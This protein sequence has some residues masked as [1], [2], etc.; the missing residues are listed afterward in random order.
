MLCNFFR[1]VAL[2]GAIFFFI[3][4]PSIA[5]DDTTVEVKIVSV[6]LK[7]VNDSGA[8]IRGLSNTDFEVYEDGTKVGTT[9]FEEM[10]YDDKGQPVTT[11]TDV[12]SSLDNIY[13]FTIFLDLYNISQSE[14]ESLRPRIKEFL[15]Q[16]NGRAEVM[17][18]ALIPP[19]KLGVVAK[20]TPDISKISAI[21]DQAR[22]NPTRD[23]DEK[24]NEDKIV[25]LLKDVRPEDDP[26]DSVE[27]LSRISP[28]AEMN[29]Q[30]FNNAFQMA[31]TFMQ[32]DIHRAELSVNA[33][34]SF[35]NYLAANYPEGHASIVYVS[36]GYSSDPGRRYYD[37]IN[38]FADDLGF[39]RDQFVYS[40]RFP[41]SKRDRIFDIQKVIHQAIGKL[42]RTNI[43]VYAIN[44]RGMSLSRDNTAQL[45][46]LAT[47]VGKM[48]SDFQ[49]PLIEIANETG[50][51]SFQ[52]SQNFKV[53]FDSVLQDLQHQYTLCY[54]PP[55]HKKKNEF[56]EIKIVCKKPGAKLR[57]R[58]GYID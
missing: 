47:D 10:A 32:E 35:G 42:N 15:E 20:Y 50:G 53:G 39:A 29:N 57:Y 26:I 36:G 12:S 14:F 13:R 22:G 43:T 40:L 4:I 31:S 41:K 52:N 6:W 56:H 45:Q 2:V 1:L 17:V 28:Q 5:S 24:S 9:C 37:Q 3:V 58:K 27:D 21:I 49:D 55:E 18:S 51:L 44:T 25:T 46:Y 23:S 7:A 19:G 8:S 33:F 54:R 48:F 34:E 11:G 16:I 30:L 38:K